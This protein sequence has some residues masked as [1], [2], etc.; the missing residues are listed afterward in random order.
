LDYLN[1]NPNSSTSD[2]E[3]HLQSVYG[4]R[5][6][7]IS[8]SQIKYVRKQ[9]RIDRNISPKDEPAYLN[10]YS[11]TEDNRLFLRNNSQITYIQNG[12]KIEEKMIMWATES[13]LMR[14]RTLE[15]LYVDGSFDFV[16][17]GY[18]QLAVIY[19]MDQDFLSFSWSILRTKIKARI[20]LQ[21]YV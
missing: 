15:H 2:C 6:L 19:G 20:F 3:K 21:E 5:A 11:Y 8:Y 9:F 12:I 10:Q 14:L 1:K 17:P 4:D 18:T 13:Q 16:C 7:I